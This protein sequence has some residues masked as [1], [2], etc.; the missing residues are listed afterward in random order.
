MS[1][2]NVFS[3]L[4]IRT[5]FYIRKSNRIKTKWLSYTMF[6]FVSLALFCTGFFNLHWGII[7]I[8]SAWIYFF[9]YPLVIFIHSH[10]NRKVLHYKDWRDG[11]LISIGMIVLPLL[12][13]NLFFGVAIPETIHIIFVIIWNLKIAFK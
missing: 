4:Y 3:N 10:L 2:S 11:I 13:L 7:H 8:W 1:L 9:V 5:I 6:S 12:T